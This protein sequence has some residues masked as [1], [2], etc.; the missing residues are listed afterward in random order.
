MK[1]GIFITFEGG[2]GSGKTTQIEL[3][4]N[5]LKDQGHDVF[6]TREP[7]GLEISE[8]IRE[9]ILKPRDHGSPKMNHYTELLL[10]LAARAHF[11]EHVILPNLRAGKIV[12][13]DRSYD[14]TKAYQ[15]YARGMDLDLID[16]LN[17]KVTEGTVPDLT[18]FLDI[19][20]EVGLERA[21]KRQ[22][23][24]N[25]LDSETLDFHHKVRNGYKKIAE[26]NPDRFIV[27]DAHKDVDTIHAVIKEK[28]EE[29]I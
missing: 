25:R 13:S 3:L 11:Y 15:G 21:G 12:L 16:L 24:L 23:G 19:D 4:S 17:K 9:V 14:S 8:E 10:F 2:E 28:V 20:P 18:F 22:E 1:K 29:E 27:V 26:E 6:F 5:Y 7:G